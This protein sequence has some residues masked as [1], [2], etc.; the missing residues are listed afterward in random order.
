MGISSQKFC[1]KSACLSSD[2]F[3]PEHVIKSVDSA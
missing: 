2:T 1:N 3:N